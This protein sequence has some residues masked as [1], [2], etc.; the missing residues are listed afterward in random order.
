MARTP[1]GKTRERVFRFV[2]QRLRAGEPPTVREVQDAMGFA[3][4]ESARKHLELLVAA[5]RLLKAPGRSRGY[6]LPSK[7]LGPVEQVPVLGQIQAGALTEAIEAAEDF[8]PV[9]GRRD[10][11]RLFAL[12][13][14]GDSMCEAGILDDD[15]VIVRRQQTA[16]A[17]EIVAALVDDEATIKTLRFV[18]R[19]PVL[20]PAN[21]DFEPIRPDPAALRIL[22]RV[23]EVRRRY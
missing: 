12:R 11:D 13:V 18:R 23:V 2:R 15:V 16:Q 10:A 20:E 4:V 7:G 19:R 8:V 1:P 3:A 17:G 14:R 9:A 6:R 5:G 21:S 22:G